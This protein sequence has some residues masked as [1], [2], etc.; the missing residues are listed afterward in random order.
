[1]H[2][3]FI[4][5]SWACT[6]FHPSFRRICSGSSQS[7]WSLLDSDRP[8]LAGEGVVHGPSPSFLVV[9]PVPL[10]CGM[11]FVSLPSF[12]LSFSPSPCVCPAGLG[13]HDLSWIFLCSLEI[14]RSPS[15]LQCCV[16]PLGVVTLIL[17]DLTRGLQVHF[18]L[19]MSIFLPS[20]RSSS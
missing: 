12:R 16:P 3:A 1:M 18:G 19:R 5:A 17:Q 20:H 2:F 4:R 8:P 7:P 13:S 11:V 15:N 9:F 10:H 6:L 14:S